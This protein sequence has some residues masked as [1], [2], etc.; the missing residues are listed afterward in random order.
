MICH[1]QDLLRGAI[2]VFHKGQLLHGNAVLENDVKFA[3]V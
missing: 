2:T 3:F 1:G